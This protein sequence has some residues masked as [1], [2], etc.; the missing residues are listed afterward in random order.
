MTSTPGHT[1]ASNTKL[2]S[3]EI[4]EIKYAIVPEFVESPMSTQELTIWTPARL[5]AALILVM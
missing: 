1:D 5:A 3:G 2:D 4:S